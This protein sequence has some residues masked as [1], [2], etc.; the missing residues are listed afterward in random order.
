MRATNAVARH[1][2]KKKVMKRAR[3]YF[4]ARHRQ[5]TEAMQ[6]EMRAERSSFVGRKLKKREMRR[7]WITRINIAARI[8]GI[9]Y[10]QLIAGLHKADI[11]LDRK[12]LSELAIHQPAAFATICEQAKSALV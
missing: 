1:Q 12:Q 5:H 3:G 11:R 7:L 2:A 9:A 10:N 6:A 4:G 8:N